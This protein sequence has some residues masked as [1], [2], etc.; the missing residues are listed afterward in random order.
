MGLGAGQRGE[1]GE[2]WEQG[3]RKP[4]RYR[5]SNLG[6]RRSLTKARTEPE[7]KGQGTQIG[8]EMGQGGEKGGLRWG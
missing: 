5:P 3:F 1:A 7:K 2:E 4:R 8:G 6:S